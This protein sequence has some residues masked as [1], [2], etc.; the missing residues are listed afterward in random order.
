MRDRAAPREEVRR[1][2]GGHWPP[3]RAG[4]PV[5]ITLVSLPFRS[6]AISATPGLFTLAARTPSCLLYYAV[7]VGSETS[8]LY[9]AQND[10]AQQSFEYLASR[11]IKRI[12]RE[13]FLVLG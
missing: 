5:G 10:F 8:K 4:G 7:E 6:R 12:K 1:A 13:F 11:S 9:R 3:G 2:G